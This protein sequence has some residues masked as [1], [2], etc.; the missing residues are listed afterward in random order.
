MNELEKEDIVLVSRDEAATAVLKFCKTTAKPN[1]RP[2][3]IPELYEG[4]G[5][6]EMRDGE[7]VSAV[8]FPIIGPADL[9]QYP[10]ISSE[11]LLDR[12]DVIKFFD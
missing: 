7:T 10:K 9:A 8:Y 11:V 2:T 1:V 3:D 6:V 5:C 12:L 4:I